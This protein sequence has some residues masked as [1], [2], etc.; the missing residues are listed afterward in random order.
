MKVHAAPL[1]DVTIAESYAQQDECIAAAIRATAARTAGRI[2]ILEAGCGNT[3]PINLSGIN[4]R[5]TGCDLDAVALELRRTKLKDLDASIH[6]DLCTV[7]LP[8]AAF[9]VVYSSYVLEHVRDADLALDNLLP[10]LKPHGLLILRVPDPQT[11]RGFITRRTPFWFHVIYYRWVM[12]RPNAGKPGYA[13]YPTYYHPVI[14]KRGMVEYAQLHD[15][16]WLAAYS[17]NF[18]RDGKGV[19]GALFRMCAKLI[20]WLSLHRYTSDYNDL[21]YILEKA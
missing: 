3:W 16:K 15:L 21:I 13:P 9:D 8:C 17:D 5:L 18:V 4:Y 1:P 19:S 7:S 6:G 11:A 10:A 20:S 12:K 14:S 2:E